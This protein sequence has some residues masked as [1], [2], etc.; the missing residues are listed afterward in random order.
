MTGKDR[1]SGQ[2]EPMLEELA[3]EFRQRLSR[4]PPLNSTPGDP[5]TTMVLLAQDVRQ[6][7]DALDTQTAALQHWSEQAALALAHTN[8]AASRLT[9]LAEAHQAEQTALF[10]RLAALEQRLAD[11]GATRPRSRGGRRQ[12]QKTTWTAL[13]TAGVAAV[14]LLAGVWLQHASPAWRPLLDRITA[15][16]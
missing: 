13:A 15:S 8:A 2:D 7:L 14:V 5:T 10:A 11:S 6:M 12:G 16:L 1:T 9:T 3:A 4:L